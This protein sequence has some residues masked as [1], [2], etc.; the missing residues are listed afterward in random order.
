MKRDRSNSDLSRGRNMPLDEEIR[1]VVVSTDKDLEREAQDVYDVLK[2]YQAEWDKRINVIR[3]L[4]GIILGGAC[5]LESFPN[6]LSRLLREPIVTQVQDLRSAVVKETCNCI[7]LLAQVMGDRLESFAEHVIPTLFK[8]TYVT[9][10]I[11]SDSGNQ[12]IRSLIQSTRMTKCIPRFVEG[13]HTR[14]SILRTRCAEYILLVLEESPS[15]HLEK[16][17]DLLE[18]TILQCMSDPMSEVR[19][20]ARRCFWA[21]NQ[22]FPDR[23]KRIIDQADASTKKLITDERARYESKEPPAPRVLASARRQRRPSVDAT[24]GDTGE[25]AVSSSRVA[26]P[27]RV[28]SVQSGLTAGTPGRS[29]RR[30]GLG[31]GMR[32][33][34]SQTSFSP[35]SYRAPPEPPNDSSMV[36]PRTPSQRSL[37]GPAQRVQSAMAASSARGVPL[38][39]RTSAA[40]GVKRPT[41]VTPREDAASHLPPASRVAASPSALSARISAATASASGGTAGTENEDLLSS[42]FSSVLAKARS[43]NSNTRVECFRDLRAMY[44]SSRSTEVITNLDKVVDAHLLHLA[45]LQPKVAEAV[46]DSLGDLISRFG[47]DFEPFM[48]KT[49]QKVLFMLTEAKDTQQKLAKSILHKIQDTYSE[50]LIMAKLLEVLEQASPRC[51]I[52]CL[53]FMVQ[54]MPKA[55]NFFADS[56]NLRLL[57]QRAVQSATEKSPDLRKSSMLCLSTLHKLNADNFFAEFMQQPS[58]VQWTIKKPLA[59]YIP[60]FENELAAYSRA[61][62]RPPVLS[63]QASAPSSGATE[64]SVPS[65]YTRQLPPKLDAPARNS[66][67][68]KSGSMDRAT[69]SPSSPTVTSVSVSA[70]SSSSASV[71]AVVAASSGVKPVSSPRSLSMPTGLPTGGPDGSIPTLI[72]QLGQSVDMKKQALLKIRKA[73]RDNIPEMWMQY[74]GQVLVA[75]LER[76][77]DD[78]ASVREL[79]IATIKEMLK[80]QSANFVEFVEVVMARLLECYR[81]QAREV[82]Q[83]AEEALEQLIGVLDSNKCLEQL[84]VMIRNEDGAVLQASIR[85]L[86]KIVSRL[87]ADSLKE[88]LNAILP[89]LFDAF[90][91][92]NADVR[93]AVVFALVDMYLVMGDEFEPFLKDLNTSQYKLVSIYIQRMKKSKENPQWKHRHPFFLS[94][95]FVSSL[96]LPL[97][98]PP[99]SL[100]PL[101][102]VCVQDDGFYIG[103]GFG[104][105]NLRVRMTH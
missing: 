94:F 98:P 22:H 1:P 97:S 54:I 42:D 75:V 7:A 104:L 48:E 86:A 87:P 68:G 96:S 16:H 78:E 49:F 33:S 3:R 12:C 85:L 31:G 74:F 52:G 80:N 83:V 79:A 20:T 44:K 27:S 50:D 84:N 30:P 34:V 47:A 69:V 93:K 56:N 90:R 26:P 24:E 28:Q 18:K 40:G 70:S 39:G 103:F 41:G 21:F 19:A 43:L 10:Q 60:D 4:E 73:S 37:Q 89:G 66:P 72:S 6:V 5:D 76:V 38:S 102:V 14:S 77:K 36:I 92:P 57:V 29:A 95:F 46:S 9:I 91:N 25:D 23:C 65:A 32:R 11:I 61:S 45:D 17:G 81:D 8:L 13:L 62:R 53:D 64:S 51:K 58:S 55:R 71:P 59:T 67:R 2:D 63:S 99:P 100:S 15:A 88:K 101:P 82:N 105:Q 35:S